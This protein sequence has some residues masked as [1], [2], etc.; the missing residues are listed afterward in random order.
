MPRF[1]VCFDGEPQGEYELDKMLEVNAEGAPELCDWMVNARIG[2][3]HTEGGGAS[4]IVIT[5]RV[6]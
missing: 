2:E 1:Q 5:Q 3:T 6:E 4:P